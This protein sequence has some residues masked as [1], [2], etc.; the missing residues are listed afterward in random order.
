MKRKIWS[1]LSALSFSS[2]LLVSCQN[3]SQE[4]NNPISSPVSIEKGN[5]ESSNNDA[6]VDDQKEED[7]NK[8]PSENERQNSSAGSSSGK[9]PESTKTDTVKTNSETEKPAGTNSTPSEKT[10]GNGSKDSTPSST[11]KDPGEKEHGKTESSS[12]SS[13]N[14]T[15][16]GDQPQTPVGTPSTLSIK[17]FSDLDFIPRY[18]I[19]NTND[20]WK[21]DKSDRKLLVESE[22][23]I[24]EKLKQVANEAPDILVLEGS[25]TA[26]GEKESHNA[27]AKLIKEQ[28]IPAARKSNP[29]ATVMIVP[30]SIDINNK[31]ARKYS[32]NS[33]VSNETLKNPSNYNYPAQ[34]VNT[35]SP[36]EF[37]D[38]YHPIISD[39]PKEYTIEKYIDSKEFKLSNADYFFSPNSPDMPSNLGGYEGYSI[40]IP[41]QNG[42]NGFTLL[43]IDSNSY[44][45]DNAMVSN[46]LIEDD[47]RT[48]GGKIA[49]G[50]M[51]WIKS[52]AT[53][54]T[55]NGDAVLAFMH[56]G[57]V[58]HFD[59]EP[60]YLADYLVKDYEHVASMFAK[61][62][63]R[64]VFT[65]H[66]HSNDIASYTNVY[67]DKITDIETGSLATYPLLG[68]NVAVSYGKGPDGKNLLSLA[69]K[70]DEFFKGSGTN[71]TYPILSD[72]SK[73]ETLDGDSLIS[74]AK[75]LGFVPEMAQP[76]MGLVRDKVIET[77][78]GKGLEDFIGDYS[79]KY[80][81][82]RL[83]PEQIEIILR[84]FLSTQLKFSNGFTVQYANHH[85]GYDSK[86]DNSYQFVIYVDEWYIQPHDIHVFIHQG[87]MV[88]ILR[89]MMTEMQNK[90]IN[91]INVW[92]N[93]AVAIQNDLLNK[94]VFTYQGTNYRFLDI[95]NAIYQTNLFGD[96]SKNLP[97][98]AKAAVEDINKMENSTILFGGN[99]VF[100]TIASRFVDWVFT[101][102]GNISI[103]F[104]FAKPYIT[105]E[106]VYWNAGNLFG[107]IDPM[108]NGYFSPINNSKG[109]FAPFIN[110]SISSNLSKAQ[111]H[112][113]MF[114]T[115]AT[116]LN[117]LASSM[118]NDQNDPED[119]NTT[120][121]YTF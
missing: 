67:G 84:D 96:E 92:N 45:K 25:L 82:T 13:S 99:G 11:T 59:S 32:E 106:N 2:L 78:S 101:F 66:M 104:S 12:A 44:S 42:Q 47:Y 117:N 55:A 3:M 33:V 90:V 111:K 81:N 48:T 49:K 46:P 37:A 29:K 62:G 41:G 34:K 17:V 103:P 80:L 64:Y 16:L 20:F 85:S 19:A 14:S 83:G 23:L 43:S 71:V 40:H 95:A 116:I 7:K 107:I 54:A 88:A 39:L 57:V 51:D 69:I 61:W 76:L 10:E 36:D 1:F 98:W 5:S 63:I 53:K 110:T 24:T 79:Q 4:A 30:G 21:Q 8:A 26:A 56:H 86:Y 52:Q 105:S 65:G 50:E 109:T 38:I 118:T 58:P 91:D 119:L 89:H 75:S 114:Y 18:Y 113:G 120:L 60:T 9:V 93:L 115:F 108:W 94:N 102:I 87:G 100:P 74:Y 6:V 31:D 72:P 73:T 77:M 27:L 15:V 68:R 97:D 70:P 121:T 112:D 28:Y 22:A 35:V